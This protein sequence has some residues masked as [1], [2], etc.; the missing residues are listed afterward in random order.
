MLE[1]RKEIKKIELQKQREL[2]DSI[3]KNTVTIKDPTTGKSW[4]KIVL[5]STKTQ[6]SEQDNRIKIKV[7]TTHDIWF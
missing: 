2:F 7:F 1:L 6:N 5:K 4:R 3:L